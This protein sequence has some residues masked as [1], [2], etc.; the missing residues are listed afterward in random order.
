MSKYRST[1]SEVVCA[2][3]RRS[4]WNSIEVF[5]TL[6]LGLAAG[7]LAL[8]AYG[9]GSLD[10][11]FASL[12]VIWRLCLDPAISRQRAVRGRVLFEPVVTIECLQWSDRNA[13]GV[14]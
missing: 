12:V 14:A 10:E 1:A 2:P 9:V 8:I 13:G 4:G 5:V 3:G 7:P 6:G 11:V